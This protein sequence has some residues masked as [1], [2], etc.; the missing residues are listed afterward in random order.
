MNFDFTISLNFAFAFFNFLFY[1]KQN[2]C[3]FIKHMFFIFESLNDLTSFNG[4]VSPFKCA[5]L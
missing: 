5:H 2:N 3:N 1:S 4:D